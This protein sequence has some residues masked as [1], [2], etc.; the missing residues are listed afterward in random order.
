MQGNTGARQTGA[1]LIVSLLLLLVMTLIGVTAMRTTALE[2]RMAG[3]MLDRTRAFQAAESASR[4]AELYILEEFE[5]SYPIRF[6]KDEDLNNDPAGGIFHWKRW[7]LRP[8]EEART[9]TDFARSADIDDR[10]ETWPKVELELRDPLSADPVYAIEQ[11]EF[12]EPPPTANQ[13]DS[14]AADA[15]TDLPEDQLFRIVGLG[16][17]LNATSEVRLE[18]TFRPRD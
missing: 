18:S 10:F 4:A 5:N 15:G 16:R 12:S 9:L 8:D 2:E 17:G 11:L 13:M 7:G 3:G 14:L 6:D 1:V